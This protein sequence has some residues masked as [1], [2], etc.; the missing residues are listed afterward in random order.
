MLAWHLASIHRGSGGPLRLLNMGP[1]GHCRMTTFGLRHRNL[2][3]SQFLFV[4][5]A[6]SGGGGGG[7]WGWVG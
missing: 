3:R 4:I 6:T 7:G 1:G 2:K 5:M